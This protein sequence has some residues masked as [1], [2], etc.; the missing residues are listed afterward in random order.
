MTAA[1]WQ[2]CQHWHYVV[3]GCATVTVTDWR[4]FMCWHCAYNARLCILTLTGVGSGVLHVCWIFPCQDKRL[5]VLVFQM[6]QSYF[7]FGGASTIFLPET[8][9]YWETQHSFYTLRPSSVHYVALYT[10]SWCL[11]VHFMKLPYQTLEYR[12]IWA[13]CGLATMQWT[14]FSMHLWHLVDSLNYDLLM[15]Q[16]W[17]IL[18]VLY[19]A[20]NNR[21]W[22]RCW[23]LT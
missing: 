12:P 15:H 7:V 23:R 17:T 2:W 5:I 6:Y 11:F 9:L 18:T 3:F 13:P 22:L 20:K 14:G 8:K 19:V 10:V 1:D 4:C 21:L 16:I